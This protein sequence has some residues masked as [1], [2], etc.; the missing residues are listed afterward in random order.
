MPAPVGVGRPPARGRALLHGPRHAF[1]GSRRLRRGGGRVEKAARRAARWVA[2][3]AA[4]GGEGAPAPPAPNV[5]QGV[6][7]AMFGEPDFMDWF[8]GVIA[9]SAARPHLDV[10]GRRANAAID[11]Q[12]ASAPCECCRCLMPAAGRCAHCRANGVWYCAACHDRMAD[13]T[14]V[15][16]SPPR[17]K[18]RRRRATAAGMS[19][20]RP[21]AVPIAVSGGCGFA[22]LVMPGWMPLLPAMPPPQGF[23]A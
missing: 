10:N 16:T 3:G 18:R 15:S 23:R 4:G 17:I 1:T 8:A 20:R 12:K 21:A 11:D 2:R 19:C 6:G 7:A 13:L 9:R 5:E 22:M 14:A